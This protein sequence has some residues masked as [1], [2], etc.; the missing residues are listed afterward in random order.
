[1]RELKAERHRETLEIEN[2]NKILTE[3]LN[4]ALGPVNFQD[5]NDKHN[6]TINKTLDNDD[7][8]IVT[9]SGKS[10]K[11]ESEVKLEFGE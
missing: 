4:G 5:S 8:Q 6:K 7:D 1:M 3:R 9:T 10:Y 11:N 2:I